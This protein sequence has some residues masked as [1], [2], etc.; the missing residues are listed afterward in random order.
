MKT[1]GLIIFLCTLIFNSLSAQIKPDSL[2]ISSNSFRHTFNDTLKLG[3][4]LVENNFHTPRLKNKQFGPGQNLA[5]MPGERHR[6]T[7][8]NMEMPVFNPE[9]RSTM[10]VLKPDS[11]VRYNMPIKKI[12]R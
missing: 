6:F 3:N 7:Q 12:R 1:S 10:P 9:F 8:W 11:T 5:L 4:P 2:K